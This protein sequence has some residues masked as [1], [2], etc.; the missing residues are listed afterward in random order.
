MAA[1]VPDNITAGR[2]ERIVVGSRSMYILE[3]ITENLDDA[4]TVDVSSLL[5]SCEGAWI[6]PVGKAQTAHVGI[7]LSGTGNGTLTFAMDVA[8]LNGRV[9][10]IGT[11]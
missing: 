11:P 6:Q 3:F 10:I 7:A 9:F 2:I 8:N 1:K 4:D 5:S